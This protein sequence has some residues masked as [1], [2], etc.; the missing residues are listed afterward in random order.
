MDPSKTCT[1]FDNQNDLRRLRWD[2]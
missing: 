2:N 1:K